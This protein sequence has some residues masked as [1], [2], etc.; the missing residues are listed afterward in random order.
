[1]VSAFG[2]SQ[3]QPAPGSIEYAR[4]QWA[5]QRT[6]RAQDAV[7]D[8][9]QQRQQQQERGLFSEQSGLWAIL[10]FLGSIVMRAL[11][12]AARFSFQQLPD[13]SRSSSTLSQVMI[14]KSMATM[15]NEALSKFPKSS[16]QSLHTANVARQSLQGTAA[17]LDSA[18]VLWGGLLAAMSKK[19]ESGEMRGI[20]LIKK[21][22]YDETPLKVRSN[23]DQLGRRKLCSGEVST[24]A[25]IMQTEMSLHM[26][27]CEAG[28][29]RF[30][31]LSGF[32][33]TSL[34]MLDST[35]AEAT[36]AAVLSDHQSV[37]GLQEFSKSFAWKLQQATVDRYAANLK[38]ERSL[39]H[40]DVTWSKFTK[41]CDV[42][43]IAS[44]HTKTTS[45]LDSDVSG[46][47]HTALS[48]HGAGA[49]QT[50]RQILSS[51]FESETFVIYNV[52][53]QGH[54]RQHREQ[55]HD[56]YLPVP[57]TGQ[58]SNVSCR[59]L[60]RRYIL[61]SL[62]NGSLQEAEITHYCPYSC[63]RDY[64]DTVHKLCTYA[65]WALLPRKQPK[66]A[67]NRWTN[68]E[69]AVSWSGLLASHHNLHQRLLTKFTGVPQPQPPS[70]NASSS[71]S[72]GWDFLTDDPAAEPPQ[73]EAAEAVGDAHARGHE[74]AG[75][76][77]NDFGE[78]EERQDA[79]GEVVTVSR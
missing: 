5:T 77:P 53:P 1:M 39:L 56:L 52:P 23:G 16:S 13:S 30:L 64:A 75:P 65:V 37:P 70:I 58:L 61:G 66:F 42:H 33:P 36:K 63:C 32:I 54:V 59:T 41:A 10:P 49:L 24:H 20:L 8:K 43:V 76:V 78:E 44:V 14:F 72:G 38:A 29:G 25:K 17:I 55:L 71:S 57:V 74:F 48:Q 12:Q 60:L 15:S 28:S 67:R 11:C 7:S 40:D 4:K 2:G 79:E 3:S 18:C 51:I 34:K 27:F 31:L 46:L 69:E 35:T 68:Q 45:I 6:N 62:L 22:R 47:L 19:I 9:L 26:L 73:P 50:L 21:S